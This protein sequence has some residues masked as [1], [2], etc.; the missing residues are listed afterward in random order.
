MNSKDLK[1]TAEEIAKSVAIAA[2]KHID[3]NEDSFEKLKKIVVREILIGFAGEV[4][5]E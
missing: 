3:V 1:E 2:S 5:C 4:Y